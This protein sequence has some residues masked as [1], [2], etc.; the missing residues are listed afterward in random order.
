[1]H[2]PLWMAEGC[3]RVSRCPPCQ[4]PVWCHWLCIGDPPLACPHWQVRDLYLVGTVE[5]D[6]KRKSDNRLSIGRSNQSC[7]IPSSS[8]AQVATALIFLLILVCCPLACVQRAV[9]ETPMVS[10][11]SACGPCGGTA[12]LLPS[13]EEAVPLQ[14]D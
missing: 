10:I 3:V 6:S 8:H 5:V 1:M 13:R 7:L 12:P 2:C 11:L 4:L 9:L 14:P